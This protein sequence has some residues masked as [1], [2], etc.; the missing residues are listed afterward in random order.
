M[1]TMILFPDIIFNLIEKLFFLMK[2][3]F[4]FFSCR[5]RSRNASILHRTLNFEHENLIC[6]IH[7]L[8]KNDYNV[9]IKWNGRNLQWSWK[10]WWLLWWQVLLRRLHWLPVHLVKITVVQHR[11]KPMEALKKNQVLN[12]VRKRLWL[13]F[14]LRIV[15]MQRM[16]RQRLTSITKPIRIISKLFTRCI[17][18]TINRP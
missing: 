1:Y 3:S 13:T 4:L 8:F 11:Q 7:S 17:Q 14:G 16:F 6:C 15:T 5:R 12:K 10:K 9:N 2:T 18:I